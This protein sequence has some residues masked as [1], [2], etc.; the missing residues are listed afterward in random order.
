[1]DI[2]QSR[3]A[4]LS[5]DE[6]TSILHVDILPEADMT[7]DNLREHYRIIKK[8]TKG[9]KYFALVDVHNLYL[10]GTEGLEFALS[11]EALENR[12]AAAYCSPPLANRLNI[13][14]LAHKASIPI[15]I[16]PCKES[17][18]NWLRQLSAA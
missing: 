14:F 8:I 9:K 16:F 17:G 11:K 5:F 2:A 6:K 13:F 10:I 12:M 7:L 4:E 3:I 18:L 15:E 1:M